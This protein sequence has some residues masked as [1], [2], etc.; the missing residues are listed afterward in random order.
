MTIKPDSIDYQRVE[1]KHGPLAASATDAEH[2]HRYRL[3][4]AA[5]L[6]RLFG[7][8]PPDGDS[9]TTNTYSKLADTKRKTG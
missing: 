7:A 5:A 1:Q 3:A 4:Q 2:A 9:G 8:R 6:I